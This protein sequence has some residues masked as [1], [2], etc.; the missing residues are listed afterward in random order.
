MYNGIGL[1]TARGSGTNGYVQRNLSNLKPR[2]TPRIQP[3]SSGRSLEPD[4][5]ILEH[6]RKRKVEL[7]CIKLRDELEDQNIP[8]EQ[9]EAEVKKLRFTLQNHRNTTQ[10][11]REETKNLAPSATHAL[12]AAKKIESQKMEQALRIRSDYLEGEAFQPEIQEQRKLQ[13]RE[14]REEREKQREL[15]SLRREQRYEDSKPRNGD[16]WA[17]ERRDL[18]QDRDQKYRHEDL[19]ASSPR[20]DYPTPPSPRGRL[21]SDTRRSRSASPRRVVLR[22][23]DHDAPA[24]SPP[25]SPGQPPGSPPG[26][27]PRVPPSVPRGDPVQ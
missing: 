4:P 26:P 22:Y 20:D 5:K 6:D 18:A 13:R 21:S 25:R 16:A 8:E 12:G 17:R 15:A 14:E 23:I 19:A 24:S 10:F 1:Q 27:P 7:E 3:E 2:E 9:I 11:T